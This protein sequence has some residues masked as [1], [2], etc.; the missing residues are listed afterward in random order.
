MLNKIKNKLESEL[1]E[2]L[3]DL[4]K[5]YSLNAISPLMFQSIK[6][7]ASRKGK[8]VRPTLFIIGY[9]GFAKKI[10]PGLYKSALSLELLHDFLIVHDDIIDKSDLRRGKPSMH[11]VFN[12]YL[13]K[14]KNGGHCESQ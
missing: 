14:Y 11:N 2:Y 3:R 7:F 1:V 9:L 5:S 12:K 13:K 10:A 8:R 6:E 4:N